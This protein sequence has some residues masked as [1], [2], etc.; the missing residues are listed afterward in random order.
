MAASV[1]IEDEAF[2]DLRFD[3]LATLCQL[4]DADHARGKMAVLWRQCTAL[5]SYV[6]SEAMVR[7]VLG[8]NGPSAL[9]EA[10][11][12]ELAKDGIRICGTRGRIEWL[13][14]L[15]SNAKKGGL[16]KAAKRQP[17]GKPQGMPGGSQ[18]PA[19]S[20]P[21]PCPPAPAPA[22]IQREEIVASPPARDFRLE[23]VRAKTT[24]EPRDKTPPSWQPAV[25]AFDGYFRASHGGARPT[26]GAKQIAML[27]PLVQKHG[28]AEVVRRI[29]VARDNPPKFPPQP[30]DL[31]TFVAHFDNCTGE[32]LA[33]VPLLRTSEEL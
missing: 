15:R 20:L 3:V 7:A 26:W 17:V 30:W 22:P 10:G 11:L 4:A 16:A 8:E 14:K 24:S 32:A 21:P 13:K 9:C 5:S 6:L 27:K 2:S 25:D 1:R 18:E 31:R 23:V 33:S 28:A 29:G 19:K 12:G